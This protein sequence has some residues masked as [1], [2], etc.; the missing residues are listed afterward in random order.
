MHNNALIKKPAPEK[1]LLKTSADT[2]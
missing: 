2:R 1:E